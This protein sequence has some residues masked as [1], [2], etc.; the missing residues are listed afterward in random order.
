MPRRATIHGH[1][2]KVFDEKR[3]YRFDPSFS[4]LNGSVYLTGWWQSPRYFESS[5]ESIRRELRLKAPLGRLSRDW[6]G[7]IQSVA[8][9]AIHVR[10]G[11]YL[12]SPDRSTCSPAYYD[13]GMDLVRSR[14]SE[15]RFFVFSDDPQWCRQHFSRRDTVIIDANG[16]EGAVADLALM[17][18]CRHHVIANSSFSWWGAWLCDAADQIVVAPENWVVGIPTTD[19]LVARRWQRFYR[20]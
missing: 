7:Q 8:A 12:L 6:L 17:A 19:D 11:D 20:L 15:A 2:Y 13:A 5:S 9:V 1:S 18:A 16:P 14:V 3:I 10:R 4:T